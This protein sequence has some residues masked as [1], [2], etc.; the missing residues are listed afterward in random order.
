ML[1]EGD[2][3]KAEF[4]CEKE[5]IMGLKGSYEAKVIAMKGNYLHVNLLKSNQDRV[6]P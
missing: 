4:R 3:V 2:L 5:D 1:F 6:I